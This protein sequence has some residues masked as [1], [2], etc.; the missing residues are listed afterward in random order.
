MSLEQLERDVAELK[1]Q[2]AGLLNSHPFASPPQNTKMMSVRGM[3]KDEEGFGD[4]LAFGRYFR[5]TGQMPP[6]DWNPGDPIPE[7]DHDS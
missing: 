7:V 6:D 3:L 1:K 2:V 4:V 5:Q